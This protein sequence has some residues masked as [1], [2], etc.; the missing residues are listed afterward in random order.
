MAKFDRIYLFIGLFFIFSC[1]RAANFEGADSAL[2][3]EVAM[4]AGSLSPIQG[5]ENTV[6]RKLLKEGNINFQ[7]DSNKDTYDFITALCGEF[8]AYIANEDQNNFENRL[9]QRL[10]IRIPADNF[11][12][13]VARLEKQ[14]IKLDNKSVNVKDVTE[15]FIDIE[16]RLK[17]KKALESRYNDLLKQ[18]K[19]VKDVMAV[20]SELSTVRAE[21]ESMEGRLKFLNNRVAYATLNIFYYEVIGTDFGFATKF[22]QALDRGWDNLLAFLIG[23]VYL[24]PFIILISISIYFLNRWRKKKR[25]HPATQTESQTR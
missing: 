7:S 11:D 14:A 8:K 20:E 4:N 22:V 9:E 16:A 25:L 3:E 21:I 18:A 23:V 10:T 2:R 15:E 13:F 12:V 17:T 1:N 6:A 24:W 19:T 5:A